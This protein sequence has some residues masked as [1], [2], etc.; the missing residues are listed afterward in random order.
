MEVLKTMA[1]LIYIALKLRLL[2][3]REQ[4]HNV[5]S[6]ENNLSYNLK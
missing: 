3:W 2:L 4:S 5:F 1:P 6:K